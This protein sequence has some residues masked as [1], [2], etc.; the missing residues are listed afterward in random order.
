MNVAEKV[1]PSTDLV[2]AETLK[3]EIVFAPGGVDAILEKIRTEVQSFK[4]DISTSTGRDQIRSMAYKVARSKTA[5]DD[6]GKE[7][8]A[9]WKTKSGKVDAERRRI[10][11][12]LDALKDEV[13]KPLDDWEETEKLRIEG[14][15]RELGYIL[16]HPDFG[17][18]ET[19]EELRRRL[20]LLLNYPARDWQEFAARANEALQSEI[21][22]TRGFLAAAEVREAERSELERLRR[23]QIEREQRE[24]D[25]R[26]ATEAA[27][28]A[29][30]EAE[31]RAM[32]EAEDAAARA[33]AER[34]AI[35]RERVEAV[36]RAEKAERDRIAAAEQAELDRVAAAQA[37][38]RNRLAAIEAERKRVADIAAKEAAE[39]ARRE[40]DKRHR[41][42][43]NNQVLAALV[44]ETSGAEKQNLTKE[45]AIAI[46]T[47]IAQGK[48]P[49]TKI[50]Y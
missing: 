14:H 28:R 46:I 41:A 44:L 2:L 48:I 8:V 29:R 45:Q 37:A 11:E 26:I 23:E 50:S 15:E 13:R 1:K 22:R 20:D 25:Q 17:Q 9:E 10:R 36:A 7:L 32:Q 49:H 31:A 39:T 6:L 4:G 18:T 3:A 24:R 30:A 21:K 33:E 34:A 5:L 43:I 16:E 19:A 40:A 38:E 12:Q 42:N 35:E 47:A 27:E